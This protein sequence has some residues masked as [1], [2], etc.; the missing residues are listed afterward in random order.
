MN[1]VTILLV[2]FGAVAY[3]GLGYLAVKVNGDFDRQ[4]RQ[5][6]RDKELE[7]TKDGSIDPKYLLVDQ[8]ER[9]TTIEFRN[10]VFCYAMAAIVCLLWPVTAII[11]TILDY[12]VYCKLMKKANEL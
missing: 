4:L 10:T 9:L 1:M 8:Y 5:A 11:S 12:T 2:V 7:F 3:A 6:L